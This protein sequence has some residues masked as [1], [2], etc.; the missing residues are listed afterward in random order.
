MFVTTVINFILSSLCT[1]TQLALFI[2]VIRKTLV[3]DIDHPLLEKAA[4]VE[5]ALRNMILVAFWAAT[6]PVSIK[7]PL[8]DPRSIHARSRY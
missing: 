1:G 8:L 5:S 6:L 2:T 3:L 4:S 7:L